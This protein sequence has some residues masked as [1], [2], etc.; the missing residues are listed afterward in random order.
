[1]VQSTMSSQ[2]LHSV[3]CSSCRQKHG[4]Y[5][6][7][8][9]GT[10][11]P[12][13]LSNQS[14]GMRLLQR[15]SKARQAIHGAYLHCFYVMSFLLTEVETISQ[16]L[17]WLGTRRNQQGCHVLAASSVVDDD[18]FWKADAGNKD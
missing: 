5:V 18:H 13:L 10:I 17:C 9:G 2:I 6:L 1:M 12:Y 15:A 4:K 7:H 14:S 3:R 11:S 8:K 16:W